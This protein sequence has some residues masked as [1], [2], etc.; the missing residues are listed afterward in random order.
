M[1][2]HK[3][4]QD[5]VDQGLTTE[6]GKTRFPEQTSSCEDIAYSGRI[7]HLPSFL[8]VGPPNEF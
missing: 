7:Y 8:P 4:C 5:V 1:H 3:K 2:V 6:G